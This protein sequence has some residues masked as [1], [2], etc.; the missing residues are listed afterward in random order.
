MEPA[1]PKAYRTARFG[2]GKPHQAH[3]AHLTV[4]RDTSELGVSSLGND[5]SAGSKSEYPSAMPASWQRQA[6]PGTVALHA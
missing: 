6:N 5:G 2:Q 1:R 3:K 4:W